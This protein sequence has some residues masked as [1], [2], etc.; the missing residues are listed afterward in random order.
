MENSSLILSCNKLDRV[1]HW[2]G[3][4]VA[5]AFFASLEHFSCINL[6]TNDPDDNAGCVEEEA[7]DRPL[8][9]TKPAVHDA[10]DD[11]VEKLPP[12]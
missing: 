2:L 3:S 4:N 11:D 5:W 1:A 6:S 10:P 12:V 8:V 9:L 7:K